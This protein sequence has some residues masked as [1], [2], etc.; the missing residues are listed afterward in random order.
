MSWHNEKENKQDTEMNQS[1]TEKCSD[2]TPSW[3]RACVRPISIAFPET[4]A[5]AIFAIFIIPRARHSVMNEYR[6]TER[7]GGGKGIKISI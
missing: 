7:G 6:K 2:A 1:R 5:M 3:V 4:K